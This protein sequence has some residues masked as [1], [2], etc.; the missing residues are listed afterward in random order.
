[1][2]YVS[3]EDIAAFGASRSFLT[4]QAGM[5]ANRGVIPPV[6]ALRAA[7]A[8]IALG[9]DNNTNDVFSVMRTALLTERIARNDPFPGTLPQ[10]EDMVEDA[11]MG[12]AR[13]LGLQDRTGSI[14]IGK[15]ADL[16]VVNT[17]AAHLVPYGR[18]ISALVH[19]GQPSDIESSMVD[20][21]FLMRDRKVLTYD[22]PAI[23]AEADK[24]SRR[25][26][27]QVRE[28]GPINIPGRPNA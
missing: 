13:A 14:E 3:D 4:H 18:F 15:A 27:T 28:A 20:G 9:T 6:P 5:A 11:T 17:M 8:G 26:W 23:I 12:G 19:N 25:I 7:G 1:L 16:I 10:P 21:R 22:E 2:R 24:I